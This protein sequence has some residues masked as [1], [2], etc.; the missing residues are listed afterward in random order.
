[1]VREDIYRGALVGLLS[2]ISLQLVVV[3]QLL[4]DEFDAAEIFEVL[5]FVATY[6]PVLVAVI[7]LAYWYGA[8]KGSR[9]SASPDER[10]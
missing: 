8:V 7:L 10:R 2:L 1:M 4:S 5:G 3:I 9:A 6:V